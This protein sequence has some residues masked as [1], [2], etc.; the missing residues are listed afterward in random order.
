MQFTVSYYHE[1]A[2]NFGDFASAAVQFDMAN[3][4]NDPQTATGPDGQVDA[5]TTITLNQ[6]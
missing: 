5:S 2:Q 1:P 6:Q 3:P 4:R